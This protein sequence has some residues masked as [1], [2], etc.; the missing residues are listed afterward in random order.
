M[1]KEVSEESD[2]LR[3]QPSLLLRKNKA[4]SLA[5]SQLALKKQHEHH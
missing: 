2:Y 1:T 5:I 4:E 3:G